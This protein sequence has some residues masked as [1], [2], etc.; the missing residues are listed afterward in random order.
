M[1]NWQSSQGIVESSRLYIL[2]MS[3]H[4]VFQQACHQLEP[5]NMP[6]SQPDADLIIT[7]STTSL[8]KQQK[9][10]EA[11]KAETLSCA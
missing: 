5:L 1:K 3:D 9:R 7:F 11:R 8:S 10:E 2:E 4:L 6:E